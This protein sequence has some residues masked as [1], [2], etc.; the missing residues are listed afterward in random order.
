MED[1]FN[2]PVD[3]LRKDQR[4]VLSHYVGFTEW[5]PASIDGPGCPPS[6]SKGTQ[7]PYPNRRFFW[8]MS[9]KALTSS[10]VVPS[11]DF[12][13]QRWARI[14][15]QWGQSLKNAYVVLNSKSYVSS[16]KF[17]FVALRTLLIWLRLVSIYLLGP[18][19]KQDNMGLFFFYNIIHNLFTYDCLMSFWQAT[20]ISS[21]FDWPRK[22]WPKGY[23]LNK[24][25]FRSRPFDHPRS[26]ALSRLGYLD[27]E[28]R[29]THWS[30]NPSGGEFFRASWEATWTYHWWTDQSYLPRSRCQRK[31]SCSRWFWC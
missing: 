28:Y 9:N 31:N 19:E 22:I 4:P 13:R 29:P 12:L 6:P 21:Q 8:H 17:K 2:Q 18:S 7:S 11:P 5:A 30:R 14:M 3:D 20:H 16:F 10:N 25:S 1:Y 23:N 27:Q 26:F 24:N 15:D